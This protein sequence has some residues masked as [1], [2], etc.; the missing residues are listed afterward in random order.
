MI[1]LLQ[2]AELETGVQVCTIQLRTVKEAQG[3]GFGSGHLQYGIEF[4][5]VGSL[6]YFLERVEQDGL[7][8]IA[9]LL[10][11]GQD[12]VPDT[13]YFLVVA[14]GIVRLH[15]SR[16]ACDLGPFGE[17]P[18]F[19]VATVF[20][21]KALGFFKVASLDFALNGTANPIVLENSPAKT[22]ACKQDEQ[23]RGNHRDA[24]LHSKVLP[25]ILAEQ[26]S[27]VCRRASE[28]DNLCE[29]G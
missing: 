25:E 24:K 2:L 27:P 11:F 28:N 23:T 13:D 5:G 12:R 18:R 6:L 4:V 17:I 3:T 10:Q 14:E 22:P 15:Q 8:P 29:S 7:C 9:H 21:R 26:C 16:A 19:E 20:L 1:K